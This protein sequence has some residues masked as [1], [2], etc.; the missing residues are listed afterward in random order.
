VNAQ[1]VNIDACLQALSSWGLG[2]LWLA[3]TL[4][5]IDALGSML[6][7]QEAGEPTLAHVNPEAAQ[8]LRFMAEACGL[9]PATGERAE[10]EA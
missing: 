10:V 6:A 1:Q 5:E 9:D 3:L 7:D 8:R 4:D 2:D